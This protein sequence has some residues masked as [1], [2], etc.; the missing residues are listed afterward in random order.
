MLI[1]ID[2]MIESVC[3]ILKSI[4]YNNFYIRLVMVI[5]NYNK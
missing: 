1:S 4:F 2:V 3:V 5:A